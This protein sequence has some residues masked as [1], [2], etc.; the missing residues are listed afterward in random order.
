MSHV[1]GEIDCVKILPRRWSFTASISF[2]RQPSEVLSKA[3]RTATTTCDNPQSKSCH[4]PIKLLSDM[5]SAI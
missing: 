5:G 4:S 2:R 1:T 3:P